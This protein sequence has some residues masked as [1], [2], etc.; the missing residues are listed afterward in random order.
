MGG[1]P[2]LRHPRRIVSPACG[3]GPEEPERPLHRRP[4]R[5][6]RGDGGIRLQ[7]V[8]REGSRL[9]D[10]RRSGGDEPRDRALR[11][12]G[13]PRERTFAQRA[14]EDAVLRPGRHPGDRPGCVLP[15]HHRLQQ[16]RRRPD[17]RGQ[18]PHPGTA[19]RHHRPRRR[20]ALGPE[21]YPGR[22]AQGRL[23]RA[24]D[25]PSLDLCRA[26]RRGR[27]GGG[28]SDRRCPPP[29]HRRRVRGP[30]RGRG[31]P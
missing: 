20:P 1:Q 27:P 3:C 4:A 18:T 22:T 16:H 5:T 6:D 12:K 15:A 21:R 8:H 11:R 9:P 31:G 13:G 23:L 28:G 14:G 26:D 10:H 17:D 25:L 2:L 7:Q 29:G 19:L 24:R 30:A